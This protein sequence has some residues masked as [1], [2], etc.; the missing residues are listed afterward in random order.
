MVIRSHEFASLG[1]N[2]TS[3]QSRHLLQF[4]IF[5]EV[6]ESHSISLIYVYFVFLATRHEFGSHSHELVDT[7]DTFEN[8]LRFEL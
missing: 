7:S 2:E 5:T 6:S 3:S 8:N 4:D 1:S